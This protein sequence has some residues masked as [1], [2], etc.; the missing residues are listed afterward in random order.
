[1]PSVAAGAVPTCAA[2]FV[3]SCVTAVPFV[4]VRT[5]QVRPPR[6]PTPAPGQH[7]KPISPNPGRRPT[8]P[9]GGLPPKR[10][11][12]R[13]ASP[14]ISPAL[15]RVLA[16]SPRRGG[17]AAAAARA[18]ANKSGGAW[19]RHHHPRSAGRFDGPQSIYG[20]SEA[21]AGVRLDAASMR[22]QQLAASTAEM[23][24]YALVSFS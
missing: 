22:T 21:D 8:S 3:R 18:E 9:V 14:E 11:Q 1:M 10:L 6:E 13:A 2:S 17:A 19:G 23:S 12:A 24:L 7:F 4:C 15:Q 5:V 20:R 16:R